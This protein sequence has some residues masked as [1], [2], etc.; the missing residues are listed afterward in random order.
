MTEHIVM[1]DISGAGKRYLPGPDPGGWGMGSHQNFSNLFSKVFK[2][3]SVGLFKI[4]ILKG[5]FKL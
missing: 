4:Y 3:R 5:P 1:S 2:N